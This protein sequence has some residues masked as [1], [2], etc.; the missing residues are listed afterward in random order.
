M[1]IRILSAADIR[2]ALPMTAAIA[3]MKQAFVQLSA[4]QAAMPLRSR[5]EVA[6]VSG[7]TIGT[8][9]V[10]PAHLQQS[11]GLAVKVV[12]VFPDNPSAGLPLIHGVVMVL[13]ADTGRPL[14]LMEA[15][16]LTAIRTGAGSGAAT[17]LLASAEASIVAI[18][19]SGVQAR[20]QLEA[21]CSVRDVQEVR[22]Y[23]P[24]TAHAEK[25][26]AE[27][28]GTGPV[29][30]RITVAASADKAVSG[31]DIIC[32]AT[33]SPTPVFSGKQLK[34]GAHVN[35]V[36]SYTVAMQEVDSETVRRALVVVDAR[37]SA[38]NEAGDLV[39]PLQQ[40]LITQAHIHAEL[41]EILSGSKAGR[42]HPDQITFF[43]SVGV[44]VQDVSAAHI[45]Y[46]NALS[47]HL[48]AVVAL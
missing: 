25:M 36:G 44:A 13:A 3:G 40:G 5:L 37:V 22:I 8:V 35:G 34:P 12:S 31:A 41:G 20:T 47:K 18:I 32:T 21:V 11:Q 16:S 46:Q 45:A 33:T 15:A 23:S 14:A 29:P 26:A 24:T 6:A 38:L 42:S 27:M 4:G 10:M 7:E 19:G 30:Q 17:D 9:L 1:E 28:A 48:G 2:Q 39:V 43:K